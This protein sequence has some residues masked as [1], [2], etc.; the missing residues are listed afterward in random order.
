VAQGRVSL[1]NVRIDPPNHAASKTNVD[2][3]VTTATKATTPS[4]NSKE[5]IGI[6]KQSPYFFDK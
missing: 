4:Q 5:T 2:Y 1:G 6:S 3:L